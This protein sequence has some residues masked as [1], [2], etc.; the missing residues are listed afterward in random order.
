MSGTDGEIPQGEDQG[1]LTRSQS[2]KLQGKAASS[3]ST[4]TITPNDPNEDV[5]SSED[6]GMTL[7]DGSAGQEEGETAQAALET[8]QAAPEAAGDSVSNKSD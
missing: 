6:A 8:A 7:T 3:T 2:H 1:R 5:K 4:A